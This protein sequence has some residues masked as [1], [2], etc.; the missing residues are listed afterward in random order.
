MP[1]FEREPF[2][3]LTGMKVGLTVS[4]YPFGVTEI[5]FNRH[6]NRM[7]CVVLPANLDSQGLVF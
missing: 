3:N 6:M 1:K 4:D 7:N 5:P 2:K